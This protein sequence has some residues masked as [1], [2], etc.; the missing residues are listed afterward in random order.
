M[1]WLYTDWQKLYQI[2]F[3]TILISEIKIEELNPKLNTDRNITKA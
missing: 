3:G 1:N 2:W